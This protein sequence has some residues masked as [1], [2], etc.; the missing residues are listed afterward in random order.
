MRVR[1]VGRYVEWSFKLLATGNPLKLYP[2]ATL[3][4][5]ETRRNSE[6]LYTRANLAEPSRYSH[7]CPALLLSRA[8]TEARTTERASQSSVNSAILWSYSD[9]DC[10][11]FASTFASLLS[12]QILLSSNYPWHRDIRFFYL[13]R[14]SYLEHFIATCLFLVSCV[15]CRRVSSRVVA[16][17]ARESG[18]QTRFRSVAYHYADS[19]ERTRFSSLHRRANTRIFYQ[20]ITIRQSKLI[21]VRC[22]ICTASIHHLGY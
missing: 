22:F 17:R 20:Q 21:T 13:T 18:K 7:G 15:A 1:E 2:L 12:T 10:Y 8:R 19:R 16:L 14:D 4:S 11:V 5:V 3:R 9:N 6:S